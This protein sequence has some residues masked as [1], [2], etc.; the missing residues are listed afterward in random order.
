[1]LQKKDQ[2]LF[3]EFPGYAH[4]LETVIQAVLDNRIGLM[5]CTEK[6]T[7]KRVAVIC[8][9]SDPPNNDQRQDEYIILPLAKMFDGDPYQELNPP[10]GNES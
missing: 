5:E 10:L 2:G 7:G 6:A 8:A 3:K 1:M 9:F 4:N